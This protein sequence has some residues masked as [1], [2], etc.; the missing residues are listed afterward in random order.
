MFCDLF[1]GV[2]VFVSALLV[3]WLLVVCL[4]VV[5]VVGV[6]ISVNIYI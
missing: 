6:V 2:W 1:D 4:L 3:V 5:V